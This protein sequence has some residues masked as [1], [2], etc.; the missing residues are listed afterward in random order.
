MNTKRNTILIVDDQKINRQIVCRILEKKYHML[1]AE[2]GQEALE[3]VKD[4]EEIGVIL[5]DLVMPVMDGFAFMV[6]LGKIGKSSL[7][8][9]VMTASNDAEMEVRALNAGALDFV[10]K[11]I[12]PQIIERRIEN[13]LNRNQM[14]LF[15]K[16]E[17][18]ATHDTL[19]G[20]HNRTKLVEVTRMLLDLHPETQFAFVRFDIDKFSLYNSVMGEQEGNRLLCFVAN[21]FR[22][23]AENFQY[24][25]YGRID[26]DRFCICEPYDAELIQEQIDFMRQMLAKY[27]TDYAIEVSFGIYIIQDPSISVETIITR[28]A[29]AA[30]KCKNRYDMHYAYYDEGMTEQLQEEG[31]ITSDMED[32]LAEEQFQVYIQPKYDLTTDLP[33]GGE[34]LVRW[35]HPQKGKI[36]P[37]SFIPVFEKNGFISSLDHYMWE[38]VCMLL[39]RWI[40]EG[41]PVAPISVNMSRVSLYNPHVAEDLVELVKKYSVPP[42]LLNLEV[43]ESAYM[44]NPD[45][46]QEI[47]AKL[48]GEG[49]LILMDDFGSGYSSLNTLKQIHIDVL[50][51]DMKFLPTGDDDGKSE[52]IISAIIRMA[53]WL[54]M[55]VIA[56]GVETIEQKHFLASVGCGYVQGYYYARLM[57]VEDY[58]KLMQEKADLRTIP[59]D[60]ARIDSV[61]AFW[62][63]DPRIEEILSGIDVPVVVI[64]YSPVVTEII[65]T[66]HAY[67]T[68]YSG[69]KYFDL[70]KNLELFDE[71]RVKQTFEDAVGGMDVSTCDF[72]YIEAGQRCRWI[73]L[74]VRR[75]T[76]NPQ[77]AILCCVFEDITREKIYENRLVHVIDLFNKGVE[78]KKILVIDDSESSRAILSIMF[79]EKYDILEAADGAEGLEVLRKHE[80]DI[81]II[82][83]DLMMPNM[84]GELFLKEK[85]AMESAAD[86]PVVV[87]SAEDDSAVQL[88]MLKN[89][90]NDY[91][92]KPFDLAITKQRVENVMSYQSRFR[93]LLSEYQ[94]DLSGEGG[95]FHA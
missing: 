80:K 76:S 26:A 39:H 85:N 79:S 31:Q 34:A 73:R 48:H 2:N 11:P 81:V 43:T 42:R 12:N 25:A 77:S 61:G 6:Q 44:S 64:E 15:Q 16:M 17:Y 57:P 67:Q 41:K 62:S 54:G 72:S 29:L 40:E 33:A 58:E 46:M 70:S 32:A 53:G 84:N 59:F 78:K 94:R 47:I 90:V 19:T 5:L 30:N 95:A 35:Y 45:L 93:A 65:R 88:G 92:V 91:I 51:L 8:I 23:L 75:I 22:R 86:I 9:I 83:L 21:I 24:C 66:N 28:A 18:L 74:K 1:E 14:V 71:L 50:K 49:F 55:D 4:H 60:K 63:S 27:R 20:V 38:H 89:G 52:K 69:Q 37:N 36:M 13:A 87:I 10:S 56:E 3:L 68:S 7:P 82:L